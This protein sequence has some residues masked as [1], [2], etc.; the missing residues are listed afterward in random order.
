[1][2]ILV[3]FGILSIVALIGTIWLF[4]DIYNHP[5]EES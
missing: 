3:F 4:I 1:M 5:Q 2:A